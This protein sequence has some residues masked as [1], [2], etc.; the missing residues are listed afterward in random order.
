MI[1]HPFV[2]F[3]LTAPMLREE[4]E[5][6]ALVHVIPLTM[7]NKTL[8]QVCEMESD[9]YIRILSN[10]TAIPSISL[11]SCGVNPIDIY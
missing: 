2:M 8:E 3:H 1:M 7:W 10:T 6:Y 9:S 11:I 5:N 4:Y